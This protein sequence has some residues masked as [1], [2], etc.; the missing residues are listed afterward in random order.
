MPTTKATRAAARAKRRSSRRAARKAN[1]QP[2]AEHELPHEI[3]KSPHEIAHLGRAKTIIC[4][5]TRTLRTAR[6]LSRPHPYSAAPRPVIMSPT[7]LSSKVARKIERSRRVSAQNGEQIANPRVSSTPPAEA[8]RRRRDLGALLR[9]LDRRQPLYPPARPVPRSSERDPADRRRPRP[10]TAT[11]PAPSS[12]T[13]TSRAAPSA[14]ALR[15][16]AVK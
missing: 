16:Q 9:A 14:D 13:L 10:P 5:S 15:P 2:Y 12:P 1:T 11:S 3:A 4:S 8:S 6:P 7:P